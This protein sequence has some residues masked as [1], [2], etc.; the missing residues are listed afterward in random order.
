MYMESIY[1]L[2]HSRKIK[3][4]CMKI[5]KEIQKLKMRT[6]MDDFTVLEKA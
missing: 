4:N 6:S 5:E 1:I 3:R 2:M